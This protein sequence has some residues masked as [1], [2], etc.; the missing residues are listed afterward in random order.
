[1][2]YKPEVQVH[3]HFLSSEKLR[4]YFLLEEIAVA[5]DLHDCYTGGFFPPNIK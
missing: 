5:L 2:F 4:N 1:M 3:W